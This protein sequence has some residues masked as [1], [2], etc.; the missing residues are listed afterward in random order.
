M[1]MFCV[2]KK[3]TSDPDLDRTVT[4][5]TGHVYIGEIAGW[6]GYIVSGTKAQL[7]A[8]NALPNVYGL[9]YVTEAEGAHWTELDAA[10]TPA[11]RTRLNTWLTARSQTTIPAAWTN[12]QVI[13]A[14]F[15]RMRV[16]F[17]LDQC[18]VMD[19]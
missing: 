4:P 5:Y 7:Q 15:K 16:D 8:I 11:I 2:I 9:A 14:I 18:D 3:S 19:G 13:M 10:I 6:G 1:K 17:D 12:K